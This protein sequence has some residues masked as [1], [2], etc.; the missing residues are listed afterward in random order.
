MRNLHILSFTMTGEKTASRIATA[1]RE[2]PNWM[3]SE[4]RVVA[5]AD[6]VAQKFSRGGVLVFVGA[7]G[8]AVRA[9][10]PFLRSKT[11]DPAVIVVDE[12]CRYV[13]PILSGH[14]GGANHLAEEIALKIGAIPVIT[15]ATDL[16][17]IFTVDVF[18]TENGY[19]ILDPKMIKTISSRL[20]DGKSVGLSSELE[21]VGSLPEN[22]TLQT[23]GEVGI[24]IGMKNDVYPFKKTLRLLPKCF[25]VGI[26]CRRGIS[27]EDLNAFFL[28]SLNLH[29]ISV[30]SIGTLSSITLKKDEKA[31]KS[32][33]EH[34]R[35]HFR[36]FSSDELQTFEH[37]FAVSDF[38]RTKTGVGN[39]CEISAWL[40]S[41]KGEMVLSKTCR[42][43]MTLAVAKEHWQVRFERNENLGKNISK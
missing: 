23:E 33:A 8:I 21:I 24:F 30:E 43:G 20:L 17:K 7:M 13:I 10:A 25:H 15:T 34:Y 1:L 6:S 41:K 18:A 35:I 42:S 5:L 14:I 39:V 4:E 12:K 19:S 16:N 36:T 40:S 32:L 2:D 29:N 28:D 22:I 9:V 11:T 3:V 31:I 38:V 37:L 26:G 27:F